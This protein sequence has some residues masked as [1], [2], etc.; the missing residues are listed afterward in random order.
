MTLLAVERIK[1]FSTRSPWWCMLLTFVLGVGPIA[2]IFGLTP[3]DPQNDQQLDTGTTEV[4][5]GL[6]M[7]V[8]LVMAIIAVTNEYRFGTIKDTFTAVPNRTAALLAKTVVVAL[9][10]GVVG[11]ITGFAA[12]GVARLVRPGA[13]IAIDTSSEWR[14][15]AGIGL[16]FALSAILATAV[17]TLLRSTA[18]AVSIVL[19]WALLVENLVLLIPKAGDDIKTWMPFTAADR[20]ITYGTGQSGGE[21]SLPYHYGPWGGLA[22]FAGV[23]VAFL[24]VALVLVE[25][26]DA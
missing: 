18:A 4:F 24:V 6:A 19:V 7:M 5:Y 10:A 15:V 8:T 21:S 14:T 23:A 17:G 9:V 25:R 1:L 3:H 2:L 13:N 11:E 26:R 22:Y 20:F 16:I 12:W